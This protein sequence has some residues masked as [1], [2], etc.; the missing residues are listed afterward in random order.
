M[1]CGKIGRLIA[2]LRREKDMTQKDLADRLGISNK[3]VSKWENG[4]GCPDLSLWE[5]LSAVLGADVRKLLRGELTPN[6]PDA[7][8]M[9]RVK[10]Y[11]CPV[12]GNVL[13]STGGAELSCC[14]RPLEP[15][16]AET[17][18]DHVPTVEEMDSEYYV[19]FDH[20]MTKEHYLRFAAYVTDDRYLLVRLYPE[21]SAAFRL[22]MLRRG[23]LYVCC[24]RDGLRKYPFPGPR[25]KKAR[26]TLPF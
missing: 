20:P 9:D 19:T 3:T 18:A 7:G 15:L 6:R 23:T 16:R 13:T 2:Q 12:C 10:F 4:L 25:E 1:D 26:H 24:N 11:L 21:Q 5:D 17:E 22:P 14:G 8:R